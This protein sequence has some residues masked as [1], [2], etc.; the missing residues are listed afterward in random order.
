M[1]VNLRVLRSLVR[2]TDA[3]ELLDLTSLGLLVET[4][5]VTLLGF[6][7]GDVNEDFDEGEWGVGVLGIGVK[8]A[9]D[10]AVGF[11][12]RDEGCKGDGG[13]VGEK[14]GDLVVATLASRRVR[15]RGYIGTYLSDSSNV[16][17]SIL[18]REAQVL[19]QAES[20]IVTVQSVGLEAKVEEMLLESGGNSRLSRRRQASEPDGAALLLAKLATLFAGEARVPGD[21][22]VEGSVKFLGGQK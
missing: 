2:G 11:V 8:V 9:G 3:R 12:G 18:G 14:F 19:V 10:L 16:L 1:D 4:L 15:L 5:G 13:G 17:Y 6:F 7:D 20:D 21:V 22:A